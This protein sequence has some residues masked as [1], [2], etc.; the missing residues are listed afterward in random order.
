MCVYKIYICILNLNIL[1]IYC[2]KKERFLL[3]FGVLI[4]DAISEIA[5]FTKYI[6]MKYKTLS[7]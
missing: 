1:Q 3:I 6:G 5:W 4:I 2:L 7:M